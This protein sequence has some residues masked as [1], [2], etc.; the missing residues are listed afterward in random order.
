VVRLAKAELMYVSPF[1]PFGVE[2]IQDDQG[3][4]LL[5]EARLLP[6]R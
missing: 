3:N 4:Q 5:E 6:I 1:Q 2:Q